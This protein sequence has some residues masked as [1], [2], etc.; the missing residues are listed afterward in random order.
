MSSTPEASDNLAVAQRFDSRAE[1]AADASLIGS[2]TIHEHG[3]LSLA[4]FH[5]R[6]AAADL[7]LRLGFD[8]AG[9]GVDG[10]TAL[11]SACWVGSVSFVER[12]IAHG[13]VSL[14]ARDPT[15]ESTP[16]GWA[17]HFGKSEVREYLSGSGKK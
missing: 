16:L 1:L 7:M 12:L 4:I 8:P 3:Q 5:E 15:H 2:L 10:G 13:G 6:F 9:P 11:H 17:E 14:E